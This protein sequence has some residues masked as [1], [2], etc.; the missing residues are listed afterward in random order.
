MDHFAKLK[1]QVQAYIF[2]L[3]SITVLLMVGGS[4][5]ARR[6]YPHHDTTIS[7]I[8]LVVGLLAVWLV[9]VLLTNYSLKPLDIVWRAILHVTP[10]YANT[11]P[12]NLEENKIGQELVTTLA[13]QVYQ[14]ASAANT[15]ANA[16]AAPILSP[17]AN[18]ILGDLPLPVLAIAPDQSIKLANKAALGYLGLAEAAV[19]G[20]NLYSVLDLSFS[21]ENSLTL[22]KWLQDCRTHKAT[23]QHAWQ[24]ARLKL[25]DQ[26]T[27]KQFDLVAAYS[28]DNPDGIEVILGLF[29]QTAK[30]AGDDQA[31][32]FIALAVHELRTPLT[33]LR[34]YIEVFEDE[35]ADKLDPELTTFMQRMQ[36][37]AQQLTAFVS[38]IL[39]VARIQEGQLDLQLTEEN[40]GALLKT[41]ADNLSMTAQLHNMTISYS[42][43]P[44]VPTVGV[45]KVSITEVLNNLLDN[46]IKYSGSGK[47]VTIHAGV[48]KDGLVETTVH[49]DGVGIAASVMPTLFEK[50]HRNYHNRAKISGTGL[51]LYLS[52]SLVKAHGGNIWIKSKE[53]AGTTVGFTLQPY[54]ALAGKVKDSNNKDITRN[55]HGW[56]KNHSMYRR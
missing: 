21:D 36:A 52:S 27:I 3:G 23:D 18:N 42:V 48:T 54:S 46:A 15:G 40:W 9:S 38:N 13:L 28:K 45:D 14:L 4:W 31:V 2:L 1:R 32:D 35:L 44:Q 34:G 29:D 55:A 5:L 43:D 25:A 56:I 12:P 17:L 53:G 30:Y 51:G 26:T 33:A 47:V 50:F 22:D 19:V 20:Q 41:T 49:D 8:L 37:S 11:A 39:N 6:L 7:L 10:G 24:R 16:T